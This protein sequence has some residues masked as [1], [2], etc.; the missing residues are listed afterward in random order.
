MIEIFIDIIIV[1]LLEIF[2]ARVFFLYNAKF[3][4][5]TLRVSLSSPIMANFFFFF[6]EIFNL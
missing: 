3:K 4:Y 2:L 5:N 1:N 6:G